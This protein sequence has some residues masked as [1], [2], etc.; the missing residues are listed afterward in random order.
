MKYLIGLL[1]IILL[2]VVGCSSSSS[3][4]LN[5]P[6]EGSPILIEEISYGWSWQ[7]E[8]YHD[9]LQSF[10]SRDDIR[11]IAIERS[12]RTNRKIETT[13]IFYQIMK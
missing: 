13:S 11:V 6:L 7:E 10:L 1:L 9:A 4:A 5:E 2:L 3:L 12:C 8:D